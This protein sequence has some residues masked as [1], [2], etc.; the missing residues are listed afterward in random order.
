MPNVVSYIHYL[1]M[2]SWAYGTQTYC[3]NIKSHGTEIYL[4]SL[5]PPTQMKHEL[6]VYLSPIDKIVNIVKH[7]VCHTYPFL[8]R[9]KLIQE[10]F[11]I[12]CF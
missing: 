7:L 4:Y 5:V 3:T 10:M 2:I 8:P 1:G 6:E 11:L 9:S 12:N